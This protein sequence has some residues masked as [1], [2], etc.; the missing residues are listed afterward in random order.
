MTSPSRLSGIRP[1][2]RTAAA[3]TGIMINFTLTVFVWQG[4]GR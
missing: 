4:N 1:E 3:V 2:M